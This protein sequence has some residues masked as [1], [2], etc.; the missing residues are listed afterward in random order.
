MA[1]H[2]ALVRS[3]LRRFDGREVK[4]TGDG[5]LS[6]F[7]GPARAIRCARVIADAAPSELGLEVRA[8][9]HTGEVEIVGSDLRGVAVHIAARVSALAGARE[10]LVSSTVKELITGSGIELADRGAHEL[11][12]VP[13]EWRIYSATNGRAA[14]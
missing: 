5:F 4:H 11:K 1:R 8:G 2:D 7:D 14:A 10:V 9:I 12:G 13:G 6:T 3:Q